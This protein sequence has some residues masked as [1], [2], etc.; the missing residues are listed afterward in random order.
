ML[1]PSNSRSKKLRSWKKKEAICCALVVRVGATERFPV[2]QPGF[3]KVAFFLVYSLFL[4]LSQTKPKKQRVGFRLPIAD[5]AGNKWTIIL[6][7]CASLSAVARQP[8]PLLFHSVIGGGVCFCSLALSSNGLFCR[9]ARGR[10]GI[11][12]ESN[13]N[14]NLIRSPLDVVWL[15]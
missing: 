12:V 6:F 5:S 10:G 7:L 15:A 11:W 4:S 2:F 13:L 8:Q 9:Q 3:R 14:E 1:S